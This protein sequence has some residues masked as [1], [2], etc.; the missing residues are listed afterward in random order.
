VLNQT[1]RYEL[2]NIVIQVPNLTSSKSVPSNKFLTDQLLAIDKHI[3]Q[4]QILKQKPTLKLLEVHL[5]FVTV[6]AVAETV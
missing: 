3:L 6:T 2:Y 5:V 4:N 1:G